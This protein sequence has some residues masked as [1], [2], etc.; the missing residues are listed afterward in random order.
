MSLGT[1]FFVLIFSL[2]G[3]IQSHLSGI[4]LSGC[5]SFGAA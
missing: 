3:I 1:H 4:S 5:V 2:L